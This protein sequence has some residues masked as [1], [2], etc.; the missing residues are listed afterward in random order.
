[1][2]TPSW[3]HRTIGIGDRGRDVEIVRRLIAAPPNDTF[4]EEDAVEIR[5]IQNTNGLPVTGEVD[6]ATAGVLGEPADAGQ[7][8]TWFTR[9]IAL[10]EMGPDVRR[11]RALL[12]LPDDDRFDPDAE[13]AV[14][15]L[16]SAHGLP[17]TGEVDEA[18]ALLLGE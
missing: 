11:V 9:R 6:A 15:R 5:G 7:V 2:V 16:Q 14:R 10:W 18:E 12:E 4:D 8:P 17:L 3:W 1:M 13:A